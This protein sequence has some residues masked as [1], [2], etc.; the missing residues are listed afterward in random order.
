[1]SASVEDFS[2]RLTV[3]LAGAAEIGFAA[4]DVNAGI[5]HRAI[6]GYPGAGHRMPVCCHAMRTAMQPGDEI[7]AEPPQGN[8]ASL[9]IRY[10][11]PR[12]CR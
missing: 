11:I 3:M 1:M 7:V 6:G 10:R 8:G 4:V 12:T 9:T 2:S 5:L